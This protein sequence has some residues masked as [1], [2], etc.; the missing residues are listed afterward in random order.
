MVAEGRGVWLGS[1]TCVEVGVEEDCGVGLAAG[2]GGVVLSGS[3]TLTGANTGWQAVSRSRSKMADWRGGIQPILLLYRKTTQ[4]AII[5][6]LVIII[7]V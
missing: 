2:E 4:L 6:V 3:E 7:P 1:R 5:Q